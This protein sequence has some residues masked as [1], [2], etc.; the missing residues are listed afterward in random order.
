MLASS[1]KR[2]FF[3]GWNFLFTEESRN[4]SLG[5]I[6]LGKGEIYEDRF[7][8]GGYIIKIFPG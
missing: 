4:L 2:D 5:K 3:G 6:I 8:G 7:I 1:A